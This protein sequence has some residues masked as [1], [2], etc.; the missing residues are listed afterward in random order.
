MSQTESAA[1]PD[2]RSGNSEGTLD[3]SSTEDHTLILA[4]PAT[5]PQLSTTMTTEA[6]TEDSVKQNGPVGTDPYSH[7]LESHLDSQRLA[8]DATCNTSTKHANTTNDNTPGNEKRR[9]L[10][11]INVKKTNEGNSGI[12]TVQSVVPHPTG[13]LIDDKQVAHYDQ[14]LR[15]R[16]QKLSEYVNKEA[17][18]YALGKLLPT[19]TWGTFQPLADRRDQLCNPST[20]EP[21]IVWTVGHITTTWF[22]RNGEP[23]KQVSICVIPL[24]QSLADQYNKLVGGLSLPQ[25]DALQPLGAVR[26]IKWQSEK[27]ST[28]PTLFDEVYNAREVFANK[29]DMLYY[30]VTDLKKNDLAL[31]EGKIT[32]YRSKDSDNKWSLQRVQMELTAILLLHCN[33][34]EQTEYALNSREITGLHI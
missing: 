31:M 15:D 3:A 24:S 22:T 23:E 25:A 6:Q 20:N 29:K 19:A 33:E 11:T 27:G 1:S 10:S 14:Q 9:H 32:K 12:L 5:Q 34:C 2:K 7:H 21:L 30:P 4:L 16:L 28:E 13:I 18:I 26:A 17:N 8:N